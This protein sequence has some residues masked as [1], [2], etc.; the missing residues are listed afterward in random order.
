MSMECC[1]ETLGCSSDLNVASTIDDYRPRAFEVAQA[2]A[3]QRARPPSGST[4]TQRL[5]TASQDP[6][7]FNNPSHTMASEFLLYAGHLEYLEI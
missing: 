4:R 1:I 2:R 7:N 3:N 6:A 5:S